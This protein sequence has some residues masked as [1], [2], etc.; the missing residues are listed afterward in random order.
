MSCEILKTI[1]VQDQA[2]EVLQF[3]LRFYSLT[4]ELQVIIFAKIGVETNNLKVR[5]VETLVN[6][7]IRELNIDPYVTVWIEDKSDYSQPLA[8]VNYSLVTFDWHN[9][10]ATNL[11]WLPICESWYLSWLESGIILSQF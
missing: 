2:T 3:A 5:E 7:L 6:L 11:R 8:K 4:P 10:Q 9:L 1:S